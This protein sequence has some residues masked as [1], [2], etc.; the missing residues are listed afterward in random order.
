[1]VSLNQVLFNPFFKLSVRGRRRVQHRSDGFRNARL[2]LIEETTTQYI[3]VLRI[4]E[5]VNLFQIE[6]DAAAKALE[7]AWTRYLDNCCS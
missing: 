7:I 2:D 1:M 3:E 6:I 5:T 4:A